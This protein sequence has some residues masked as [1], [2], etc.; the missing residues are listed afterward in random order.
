LVRLLRRLAPRRTV[1]SV[2]HDLSLALQAERLVVL[3]AGSIRARGGVDDPAVH[4][5]LVQVFDH[6]IRIE[7]FGDR[8]M[9]LPHLE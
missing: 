1:V 8:Y 7:R 9:A 2:L 6:A 5:A 4:A 3:Q